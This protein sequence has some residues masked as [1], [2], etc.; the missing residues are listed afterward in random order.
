MLRWQ[1]NLA[2]EESGV[3]IGHL[4]DGPLAL[5][6]RARYLQWTLPPEPGETLYETHYT[7]LLR[8][9][10]GTVRAALDVHREGLSHARR[11]CG[12]SLG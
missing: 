12:C 2:E 10:D 9:P 8:E 6:R 1:F 11:G 4:L 3:T 5:R 7:F